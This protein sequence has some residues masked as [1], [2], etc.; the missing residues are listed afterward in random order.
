MA[1][2]NQVYDPAEATETKVDDK[3]RTVYLRTEFVGCVLQLRERNYH[4]D[5]DFYA[6]VWDEELQRVR[7]V[8]TW[9]TRYGRS[10][11]F[12]EWV[13]AT[14]E[15]KAKAQAWYKEQERQRINSVR[16]AYAEL[17]R[18]FREEMRTIAKENDFP[19]HNLIRVRNG[20][21]WDLLRLG[22]IVRLILS[23]PRS[24]FKKSLRARAIEGLRSPNP[25]YKCP[26]SDN[27]MAYCDDYGYKQG[28]RYSNWGGQ[29]ATFENYSPP[30]KI[31]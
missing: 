12:G 28:S 2:R 21:R 6:V 14:E 25:K 23:K 24:E 17:L 1:I 15:V 8:E 16:C 20:N 31:R 3:G 18:K 4:D 22:K 5:S 30:R 13:D 9:T 11:W 29:G 26:L 19:Y 10:D 27:Q 7:N